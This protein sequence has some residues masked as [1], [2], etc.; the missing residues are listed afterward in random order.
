[1][2]NFL[3]IADGVDVFPLV[4]ALQ[5]NQDLWDQHKYRTTYENTPHKDVSDIWLRF[6]DVG[7][8]SDP[9]NLSPVINDSA[10]V[11]YD[12]IQKLPQV[13]QLIADLMYRVGAYEVGRVLITRLEPGGVILPHADTSG[14][15]VH[16]GDIAR[17]HIVLQGLPGSL[18]RCGDETVC[19]QTGEVWRFNAHEVH[20]VANNS[21]DDRIH[22]LVDLRLM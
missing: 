8:V 3:K 4:H 5:R 17:Y 9:S 13:K 20:E 2:R 22:L 6:S 15:Y 14:D 11:W 21:S 1:M 12:A 16:L 18:F 10:P 7:K 19:M